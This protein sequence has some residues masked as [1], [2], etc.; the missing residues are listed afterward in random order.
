[1]DTIEKM[2]GDHGL[3]AVAKTIAERGITRS[4]DEAGFTRLITDHAQRLHPG[5]RPVQAFSK[6]F[7]ANDEDGV[8]L[9]KAHAVIKNSP[10]MKLAYP[11][12]D[13]NDVAVTDGRGTVN[14]DSDALATLT[15]MAEKA[16]KPGESFA[17]AFSRTYLD[18]ANRHLVAAERQQN[19]PSAA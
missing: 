11:V 12:S 1:M 14:D 9:R 16:R 8:A 19:R 5:L 18:P 2:V 17:T 7:T 6:V 15:Q 3:V 10:M 13:G 4:V